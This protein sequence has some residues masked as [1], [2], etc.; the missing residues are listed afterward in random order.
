MQSLWNSEG[1]CMFIAKIKIEIEDPTM[2][3]TLKGLNV[4]RIIER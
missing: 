4:Y 1:G 3:S 2:T